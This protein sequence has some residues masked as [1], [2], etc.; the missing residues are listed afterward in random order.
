MKR[1]IAAV[2]VTLL[3][4]GSAR[5]P[6]Q[7]TPQAMA[8]ELLN[9]LDMQEQMEHIVAQ[10]QEMQAQQLAQMDIPADQQQQAIGLQRKVMQEVFAELSWENLKAEYIE[11]YTAVYTVAELKG[12]L[13]FYRSPVGRSMLE[14][15]P[16]LMRRSMSISQRR[17]EHMIPRI[18]KMLDD[19]EERNLVAPE[20][21]E[22]APADK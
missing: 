10:I 6:A 5:A 12:I 13:E 16:E 14:K 18:M 1:R 22:Q 21:D 15:Q 20:I 9:L 17:I 7:Q 19:F 3:W 4:F 8:E 11:L 2:L